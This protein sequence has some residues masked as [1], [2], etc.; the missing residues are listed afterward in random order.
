M[1]SDPEKSI[2]ID[3]KNEDIIIQPIDVIPTSILDTP[4]EHPVPR[5]SPVIAQIQTEKSLN[6]SIS[7]PTIQNNE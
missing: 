5:E 6:R 4:Q 3:I 7:H 1:N 2:E